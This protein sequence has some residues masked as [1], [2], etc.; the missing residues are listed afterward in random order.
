MLQTKVAVYRHSTNT[1]WLNTYITTKVQSVL[2]N[3][4]VFN[5]L[6]SLGVLYLNVESYLEHLLHQVTLFT[7][8]PVAC[9][10]HVTTASRIKMLT[11][12]L[13]HLNMLSHMLWVSTNSKV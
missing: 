7:S 10:H 4:T 8:Y 13:L 11:P 5:C 9:C 1:I 2:T 3:F 6:H 12:P